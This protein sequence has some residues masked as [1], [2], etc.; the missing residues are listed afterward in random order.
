[1][2]GAYQSV[3]PAIYSD[4]YPENPSPQIKEIADLMIEWYQLFIDMRYIKASNVVFAPHRHLRI[5]I[6][7]A[8]ELGISKDVVDLYQMMPYH[9]EEPIWNFGSDH[10]E[11]LLGGEFMPDMRGP[12]IDWWHNYIDPF[13][14]IG[15]LQGPQNAEE[16][17][18]RDWNHEDGPYIRPWYAPLMD[19][20]NHGCVMILDT[21]TS[22]MWLI[23]SD[24]GSCDPVRGWSSHRT[25]GM[26]N[27]N[28]LNQYPSRPANEFIRDMISRFRSLEWIPGGLYSSAY[29]RYDDFKELYRE[30]GWPNN[31]N[32]VLFDKK[33]SEGGTKFDWWETSSRPSKK[34]KSYA[35][36]DHLYGHPMAW[37]RERVQ[38]QIHYVDATYKLEHELYSNKWERQRLEGQ[39][40]N[41]EATLQPMKKWER[42]QAALQTELDFHR[43]DLEEIRTRTGLYAGPGWRGVSHDEIKTL[44][45]QDTVSRIAVLE[46]LL[47]D[48]DADARRYREYREAKAAARAVSPK[49]WEEMPKDYAE[50]ENDS[51]EDRWSILESGTTWVDVKTVLDEDMSLE[52]LEK[53]IVYALEKKEDRSWRGQRLWRNDGA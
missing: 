44:L 50:W 45:E 1:M 30:C 15:H 21:K 38:Q 7:K 12:D 40:H 48:K 25:E 8:A 43:S 4:V 16:A 31:F 3:D 53:R 10:G 52:E 24:G 28:D 29:E 36:L 37:A 26:S 20:G 32:P 6:K 27:G 23:A 18:T 14:L 35:P 13:Y 33:Q 42:K 17:R 46:T 41:T 5:D 22:Q 51:W 2:L 9:L 49:A 11:F 39:L 47:G 34:E 19:V